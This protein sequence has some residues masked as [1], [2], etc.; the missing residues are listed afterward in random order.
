MKLSLNILE[1]PRLTA[2]M[3]IVDLLALVFAFPILISQLST[4]GGHKVELASTSTRIPSIE[5]A[6]VVEV[7]A[8]K[9]PQ[10]WINE[11]KVALGELEEQL[12]VE[13]S[14]WIY[15]G[16]PV[17]LLKA[18]EHLTNGQGAEIRNILTKLKYSV[19][20]VEKLEE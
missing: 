17:A 18:G 12:A 11:E 5:N 4:T 7:I 1:R 16:D 3:P 10:I 8:G 9:E 19:W 6:V 13:S 15:G 20:V 2:F 14:K